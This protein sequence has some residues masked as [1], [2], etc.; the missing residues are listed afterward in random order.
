MSAAKPM[1]LLS[2]DDYLAGEVV[3]PIKHEFLA[4]V[5]HAM[6]GA[7]AGHNTVASNFLGSMHARLRGGPCQVFNSDMKVRVRYPTHT[8]FYYPDGQIVCQSNGPDALF[9]D[10]PIVIAEVLSDATRRTDAGEKRDAYCAIP[11]LSA[12][13]LIEPDRPRVI[14]YR[15]DASGGFVAEQYDGL[16]ATMPLDAVGIA[17]PLRELYERVDLNGLVD[18]ER[19]EG[20]ETGQH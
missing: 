20:M 19:E 7:R 15:R 11:S 5:V 1:P 2:V 13:L 16:D 18:E 3:S 17:L 4:G 14:A 10:Q 12:Y 8:R 6:A 9:Q